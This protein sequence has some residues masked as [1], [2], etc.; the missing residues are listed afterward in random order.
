MAID[1]DEAEVV[2]AIGVV[3]RSESIKAADRVINQQEQVEPQGKHAGRKHDLSTDVMAAQEVVEGADARVRRCCGA[4]HRGLQSGGCEGTGRSVAARAAGPG[5]GSGHSS[6]RSN[7]PEPIT[8]SGLSAPGGVEEGE[9]PAPP[10]KRRQV[11][12]VPPLEGEQV[13]LG[14]KHDPLPPT[15]FGAAR[16]QDQAANID[17]G[18]PARQ[19]G[20]MPLPSGGPAGGIG[21][22]VGSFAALEVLDQD[23]VRVALEA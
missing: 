5:R 14:F 23:E 12:P 18:P 10:D 19:R 11:R 22:P 17:V 9:L 1:P 20:E 13:G 3:V 8:A 4:G 21:W 15:V 2:L 7:R 6:R 16:G